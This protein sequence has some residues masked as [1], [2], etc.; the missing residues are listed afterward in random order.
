MRK[1]DDIAYDIEG[2]AQLLD[3]LAAADSEYYVGAYSILSSS[4]GRISEE[5]MA[6]DKMGHK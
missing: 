2:I 4:L 3:A 5:L 6:Y 1:L